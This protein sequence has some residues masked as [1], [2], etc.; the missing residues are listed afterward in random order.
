MNKKWKVITE[1]GVVEE[2]VT[3]FEALLIADFLVAQKHLGVEIVPCQLAW[4]FS[5]E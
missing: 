2:N 3:F 4:D 1:E 5:D